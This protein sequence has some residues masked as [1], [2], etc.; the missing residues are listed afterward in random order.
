MAMQK[1]PDKLAQ[2]AAAARAAGVSYGK[3]KAMQTP[4]KSQKAKADEIPEG[5]K[6][7][8]L[9]G[10]PYK[11]TSKRPQKYCGAECQQ[12]AAMEKRKDKIREYRKQWQER[13]RA[14][15]ATTLNQ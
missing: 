6:I 4:R 10:K 13:K 5:W 15:N 9:C 14:E 7:C 1:E 11:P 12:K 8:K 2:D 3:Y